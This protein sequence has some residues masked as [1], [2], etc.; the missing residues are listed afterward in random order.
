MPPAR[1]ELRPSPASPIRGPAAATTGARGVTPRTPGSAGRCPRALAGGAPS[2][3]PPLSGKEPRRCRLCPRLPLCTK[4][5]SHVRSGCAP[6]WPQGGCSDALCCP[7]GRG[8]PC[9]G[10]HT[11]RPAAPPPAGACSQVTNNWC[12]LAASS[13]HPPPP[14]DFN[15]QAEVA[16]EPFTSS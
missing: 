6:G 10:G 13:S 15:F 5:T 7:V 11:A 9:G 14:V 3:V 4:C 2:G 1:P 8:G 16:K 12:S